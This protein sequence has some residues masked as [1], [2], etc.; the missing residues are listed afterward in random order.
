M[1]DDA[2]MSLPRLRVFYGD[3]GS[4]GVNVVPPDAAARET[5]TVPLGEVLPLLVDAVRN[6]RAWLRDF[7]DDEV[8][9]S[10]DL[11]EVLLAY[12]HLYRPSA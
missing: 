7:Q 5:V 10:A 8:T 11:Y 4:C 9:L 6:R 2:N 12:L 1:T 3:E